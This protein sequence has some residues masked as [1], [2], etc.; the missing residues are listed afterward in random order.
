M[1][2]NTCA[3]DSAMGVLENNIDNT[4]SGLVL[5]NEVQLT[6]QTVISKVSSNQSNTD[7]YNLAMKKQLQKIKNAKLNMFS[8]YIQQ[9]YLIYDKFNDEMN[10]ENYDLL[11]KF[12]EKRLNPEFKRRHKLYPRISSILD[13]YEINKV[14]NSIG[15]NGNN[16]SNNYY[17]LFMCIYNARTRH[18]KRDIPSLNDRCGAEMSRYFQRTFFQYNY[19]DKDILDFIEHNNHI[20]LKYED[21]IQFG[22]NEDEYKVLIE[23]SDYIYDIYFKYA[24]NK[25]REEI[26]NR[27]V[28]YVDDYGQ[29]GL[30][31][32]TFKFILDL[33]NLNLLQDE[34][35]NSIK[36]MENLPLFITFEEQQLIQHCKLIWDIREQIRSPDYL[37][38]HIDYKSSENNKTYGTCAICLEENKYL[39]YVC[40]NAHSCCNNC[41]YK[42]KDNKCHICRISTN[43]NHDHSFH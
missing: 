17:D 37:S 5:T 31:Y 18:T 20:N 7:S 3:K 32:Y 1:V 13:E 27:R 15:I 29:P 30:T 25:I 43:D 35:S 11:C 14:L 33:H 28:L 24:I 21:F 8:I 2:K 12:Y 9:L 39:R 42:L 26:H 38:F 10:D 41:I 40:K 34:R 4:N 6:N 16:L 36:F 19:I 22:L 23:L